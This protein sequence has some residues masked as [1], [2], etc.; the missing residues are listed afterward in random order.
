MQTPFRL[1]N[2]DFA[3]IYSRVPR[4]N[5]DLIVCA[6]DGGIVLI[7]RA[8]EPHIGSWHIPGGT[9]Y[10]GE[11]IEEAAL[12]IAK[13]ETGFDVKFGKQLGFMEFPEEKRGDLLVHTISVVVE[14]EVV[15]GE[16]KQDANAR[17]IEIFTTLPTPGIPEHFAFLKE[18]NIL[19][20]AYNKKDPGQ[21]SFDSGLG[22]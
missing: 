11:R 12:R 5:V 21:E 8:I 3:S 4:F 13:N 22:S 14:V 15:G 17:K 6:Q 18:R 20:E 2:E 16:L 1:S 19:L 10:K 9:L 7:Q